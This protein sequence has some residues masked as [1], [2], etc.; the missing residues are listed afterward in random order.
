MGSSD[1]NERV[2]SMRTIQ[3]SVEDAGL[4]DAFPVSN[5]F[6]WFER[7]AIL[8]DEAVQILLVALATVFAVTFFLIGNIQ[9]SLITL[10]G[11]CLSVIDML[12]VCCF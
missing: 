8:Y 6:L 5:V 4:S 10:L 12:G 9:A 1:S 11:P 2:T 3:D 7:D